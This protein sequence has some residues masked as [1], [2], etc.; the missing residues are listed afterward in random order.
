MNLW[1]IA[2][3]MFVIGTTSLS[4]LGMAGE[5]TRAFGVPPGGAGW[6]TTLFA[7]T[8]AVAAPAIQLLGRGRRRPLILAGLA[9]LAAGLAW[10]SL[11]DRFSHLLL[12]RACA[13]IGGALVAPAGAALAI[14]LVPEERRGRALATVF[15]GFTLATVGGVPL[16]T[17]LAQGLGWRGAMGAIAGLAVL[18][19]LAAAIAIRD[20]EEPPSGGGRAAIAHLP[21]RP[22]AA[23]LATT[24]AVLAA[25]FTVYAVMAAVLVERF[26]LPEPMLPAAMLAFGIAGVGGNAAAG[27]AADR[28]GAGAV[29]WAGMGGLGLMLAAL[30]FDLGP[31]PAAAALAGCAFAGTLFTAPQQSRLAGL[32]PPP[33]HSLVLA[34]NS[35]ASYLGIGLGAALASLLFG[36]AGPAALPIA[37]L[38]VLALAALANRAAPAHPKPSW[39]PDR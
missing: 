27:A 20:P 9:L 24:G 2:F 16:A 13:A 37:A 32:V 4:V 15:A 23:M 11:A 21:F 8:F 29:V 5:I 17:W 30:A 26:A 38:A 18:C 10:G 31:L 7:G 3:A 34:L 25:Q 19:L 6:L 14:A 1:T 12:S 36:A 33:A 28:V 35:S 39:S 22:L